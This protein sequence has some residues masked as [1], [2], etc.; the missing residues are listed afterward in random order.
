M[1]HYP[2]PPFDRELAEALAARGIT[3]T[4]D[5]ATLVRSRA[6]SPS[7][8][9][10][11]AAFEVVREDRT[12]AGCAGDPDVVVSV[13]RRRKHVPG[14]PGVLYVHG[15]GMV[16]GDRFQGI[17]RVLEWV[18]AFD[19]VA[20]S[21]E[22]RLAPEHRHPAALHD[23][24]TALRWAAEQAPSLG[25]DRDRLVIFGISAG[26]GLAAATALMARD[27]G[28][29]A[30]AAQILMCPMLDDRGETVSSLQMQGLGVWD[31][32]SNQAGWRAVLGDQV[33]SD[34]VPAYA[35]PARATDLTRMPP[36]YIDCGSAEVFRD[37]SVAYASA[38]WAAGGSAEL[39]VWP[40]GFHGFE[41]IA[42][43]AALSIASRNAR[44]E[45]LRRLLVEQHG[46]S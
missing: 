15:G 26:G 22:Y 46:E 35:A 30:L 36:T 41:V 7:I 8:E 21:V 14:G 2:P 28:G 6:P 19:A 37:E 38:I 29:P 40:G 5:L 1:T 43:K 24:F 18:H 20:I 45:F 32:A 39:H 9:P 3:P 27:H 33:G 11:L 12:V 25:F 17:D 4:L 16:V 31:R 42:P 13:F 44:T 10:L 23:C 34:Q